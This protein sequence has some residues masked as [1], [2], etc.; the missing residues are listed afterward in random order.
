MSVIP[1][2]RAVRSELAGMMRIAVVVAGLPSVRG[3]AV[4]YP[5]SAL[6]PL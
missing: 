5:R 1:R 6:C 2:Q 4:H 3:V